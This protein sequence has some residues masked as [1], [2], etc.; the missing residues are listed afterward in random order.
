MGEERR[1]VVR[2]TRAEGQTNRSRFERSG[3]SSRAFGERSASCRP[4][5]SGSGASWGILC[6]RMAGASIE[7]SVASTTGRDST[8][9]IWQRT[10]SCN[11]RRG[12]R[13][14]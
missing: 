13:L 4:H 2:R 10:G 12:W 9:P 6:S 7:V 3:Q 14:P 5:A 11:F 1:A 8:A